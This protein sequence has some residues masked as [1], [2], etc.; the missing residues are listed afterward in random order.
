MS[1]AKKIKTFLAINSYTK[2]KCRLN[3]TQRCFDIGI[4]IYEDGKKT[5]C[6]KS[7]S[8]VQNSFNLPES[9]IVKAFHLLAKISL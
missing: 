9:E 6:S 5:K 2:G 4:A 8:I 7:S 3:N 1:C